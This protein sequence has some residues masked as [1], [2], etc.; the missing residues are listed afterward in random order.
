MKSHILQVKMK[1]SFKNLEQRYSTG[2]VRLLPDTG[3]IKW[4]GYLLNDYWAGKASEE[5]QTKQ[6]INSALAWPL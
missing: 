4:I 3:T 6:V 1:Y 2:S 5:F